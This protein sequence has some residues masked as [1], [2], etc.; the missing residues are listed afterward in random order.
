MRNILIIIRHE[1]IT[2]LSRRSFWLTTFA[3][4]AV[5]ITLSLGS[6][7]LARSSL[8]QDG[9]S[10]LLEKLNSGAQAVGYVDEAGIIQHVPAQ[11][12]A[13]VKWKV[14]PFRPYPD[15]AAAQA[16]LEEGR[17]SRYYVIAPDFIRTGRVTVVDGDFSMFN[18]LENNDYFEYLLRLNLT[19]NANLAVLLADP[20]A[21]LERKA[22]A[23]QGANNQKGFAAFGVPFAALFIFYFAI[24][25]TS[26]FMLQSIS[27]EKE[28]RTLELLLLSA[29]PRDLM[30]G[31]ILGLGVVALL[32]V[33]IWIGG[34]QLLTS[35]GSSGNVDL[36]DGFLFWA[37]LYF[38]LGYLLYAAVLGAIGALAP[39]ARDGARFTFLAMFP[40]FIPL[41]MNSVLIESPNGDFA[42]FLSIF[43]LTAPVT[44]VA[45]L[46]A[47][48]VPIGQLLLGLA[49]LALT[50]YVIIVVASR[51]FRADTLLAFQNI[52]LR[53]VVQG[54]KR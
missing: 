33:A 38:V 20:T 47:V 46:A 32:Q 49:L 25:M 4:P 1:I 34:E 52:S 14:A 53:R 28:N 22:L 43:P 27:K 37:L 29:R 36:P 39:T 45:R 9:S 21:T 11:L 6:Q 17:I 54:L 18:S 51:F 7:A 3:L 2:T 15:Q 41:I 44:M 40:L 30:L 24:T 12:P 50:T 48:P 26:G 31:K 16:A 10:P 8:A 5:I 13:D 35:G 19:S 23:P 42:V